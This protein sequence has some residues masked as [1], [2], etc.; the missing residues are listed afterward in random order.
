MRSRWRTRCRRGRWRSCRNERPAATQ[1]AGRR[2]MKS[3]LLFL[4]GVLVG[5]NVVY[6]VM[7]RAAV[8][9][10]AAPPVVAT[11]PA[12]PTPTGDDVVARA[13]PSPAPVAM[14]APAPTAV[15]P[16]PSIPPPPPPPPNA[17]LIP[18]AG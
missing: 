8:A 4:A 5:A 10:V 3:L 9:P 6:F 2:R 17:L 12:T 14:K 15:V 11:T 1:H 18:V 13:V 7:R 16:Q